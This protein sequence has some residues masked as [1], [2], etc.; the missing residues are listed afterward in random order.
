MVNKEG[1]SKNEEPFD[2]DKAFNQM[3]EL[4]DKAT[5]LSHSDKED[6]FKELKEIVKEIT[7]LAK[8]RKDYYENLITGLELKQ[9]DNN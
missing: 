8:L 5:E 1:V 3:L 6:A 4:N 9:I 2:P 7:R